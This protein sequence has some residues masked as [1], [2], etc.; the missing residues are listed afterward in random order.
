[1]IF[2]LREVQNPK[3]SF[4]TVE[5]KENRICQ[6]K[7]KCNTKLP[8]EAQEFIHKWAEEKGLIISTGDI[9]VK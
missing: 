4:G 1:M 2:F 8:K 5:V 7:G 6:A 3:E 9:S